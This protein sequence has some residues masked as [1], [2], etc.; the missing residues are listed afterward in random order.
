MALMQMFGD[1]F[2][3]HC[4]VHRASIPLA[5][6]HFNFGVVVVQEILINQD[7]VR[8]GILLEQGMYDEQFR[9]AETRNS[10]PS[11]HD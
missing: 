10:E 2:V 1:L 4:D 6:A 9:G 3:I 11:R 8:A 5:R 7:G